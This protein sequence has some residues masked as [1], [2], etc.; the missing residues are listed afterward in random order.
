MR[1]EGEG[2]EEGW[3]EVPVEEGPWY[4]YETLAT[5]LHVLEDFLI[6]RLLSA[7]DV[8]ARGAWGLM[9]C[10]RGHNM[11]KAGL[12]MALWDLEARLEGRPLYEYLGG[13]RSR[14]ESGVSIGITDSVEAL[15]KEV[16]RRVEE[17]YARIKVKIKPGWDVEVVRRLRE[18]FPD[19][20]LQVDANAA[21]TLRDL[22][23]LLALDEFGLEMVE[24]PLGYEDL[25][26]HATLAR[27]LRTPICLDESIRGLPD[28]KAAY[29]LGSCEVINIK[30]SRVGGHLISRAIHDFCLSVG[31]GCWIGGLLETGVGKAHSVALATLPGITHPNDISA[32]S[33]YWV[34]DIVEPEWVQEGGYIEVPRA[35]GIGVS[36]REDRLEKYLRRRRRYARG[37]DH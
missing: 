36:V 32:S 7:G 34:E 28:A 18:E 29:L 11:A 12:E 10:V 3:A 23:T 31:M 6:P 22:R 25:A 1:V 5:A 15:V 35:S 30:P 20:R 33:R 16:G 2:G 8:S 27:K 9:E 26:D 37:G 4:S 21:Y 19:V 14:I 13:V 17:G 24:Q